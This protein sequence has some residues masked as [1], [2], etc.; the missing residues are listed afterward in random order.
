M[1]ITKKLSVN[2]VRRKKKRNKIISYERITH[3]ES[4]IP[5]QVDRQAECTKRGLKLGCDKFED[6][7]D[8]ALLPTINSFYKISLGESV[9]ASVVRKSPL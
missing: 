9:M 7:A 1:K 5:L 8:P 6:D 4:G 3:N 2:C